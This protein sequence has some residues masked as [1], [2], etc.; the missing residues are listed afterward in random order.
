LVLVIFLLTNRGQVG[1][2][3]WPFP[4]LIYLPLGAVILAALALGFVLGIL[5]HLP[6]RLGANRRAKRAEKRNA[7]LEARLAVLPPVP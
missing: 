5:F 4:T 7:E 2:G 1:F 3:F 6:R